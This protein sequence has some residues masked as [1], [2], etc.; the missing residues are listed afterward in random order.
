M[1]PFAAW[2]HAL[3]AFT[4]ACAIG[5]AVAA[6]AQPSTVA[7]AVEP[8]LAAGT[9]LALHAWA[10]SAAGSAAALPAGLHWRVDRGAVDTAAVDGGEPVGWTIPELPRSGMLRAHLLRSNGSVVC[11]A[12]A[13]RVPATR[14]MDPPKGAA[15][16]RHF[17]MRD[18]EEPRGYA[19]LSYLLFPAPPVLAER[20]RFLRVL[21]AWLRQL[22]PTVEMEQYVERDQLTLFLLP[23]REIPVLKLDADA[24]DPQ[25]FR[26][27]AQ[28]LLANYD[29]PRAQALLAKMGMPA[30]GPG[31]LL[32]T[33]Q[34]SPGGDAG[35]QL[36]EDFGAVD[37]VIA[38]QWMRWSLSLVSQPRERSAE[39]LQRVAMT[40]RNVIAHVARGLPNGG[41]GAR[42]WISVAAAPAR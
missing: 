14:G 35:P 8:G 32:V 3:R 27:A 37:P 7:C 5:T 38:E 10:V 20:E 34:A 26:T 30:A 33:R 31:P 16:A 23:L 40:L 39:S 2:V 17:L 13:R 21:S 28:A 1:S 9:T 42:D 36:V 12:T 29:H 25:P 24:A 18:R 15:R 6:A 11:T 19:A 41:A 22:P 4:G